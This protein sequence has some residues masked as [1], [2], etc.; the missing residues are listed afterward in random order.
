[1][2]LPLALL[3]TS[4]TALS[5]SAQAPAPRE[6]VSFAEAVHSEYVLIP[7]VVE[8]S[9]GRFVD[10]LQQRDFRVS[11]DGRVV[12]LDSFDRDDGAP[13]SFALLVDVSGSMRNSDKLDWV[14]RAIR[15]TLRGSRPGDDF[16]LLAFSEGE[17]RVVADFGTDV[18]DLL[19]RLKELRADGNTALLDAVAST[20]TRAVTG[21]NGKR[22]ILLFTDGVDNSSRM[23]PDELRAVLESV[24]IPVYA[25]GLVTRS[26]FDPKDAPQPEVTTL[27]SLAEWSGGNLFLAERDDEMGR[28][29]S[30]I[31]KEVRRQYVL[32]F[33]PSGSGSSRYRRVSVSVEKTGRWRVR[34]RQGYTGTSPRP[35]S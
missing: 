11:V 1:M 30:K 32:G 13:V 33:R 2:R 19:R 23:S 5:L 14:K 28:V 7:A 6:M 22:A 27:A 24:S 35:V 4:T 17:V 18:K 15:S 8:D 3:L 26:P 25:I 9:R 10:G 20:T 16:A 34:T 12:G 29:V 21:R 31:G